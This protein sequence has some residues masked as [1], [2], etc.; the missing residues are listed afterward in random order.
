M[1]KE[2]SHFLYTTGVEFCRLND[3]NTYEGLER[4]LSPKWDQAKIEI[5][6]REIAHSIRNEYFNEKNQW[7]KVLDRQVGQH[8]LF[9]DSLLLNPSI[10]SFREL[11]ES[12]DPL[13]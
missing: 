6:N 8:S 12:H 5:R 10:F 4:R 11:K 2:E 1:Q 7:Q 13:K 3:P 9:E